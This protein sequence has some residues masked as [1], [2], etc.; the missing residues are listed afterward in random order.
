MTKCRA[1]VAVLINKTA[2]VLFSNTLHVRQIN[3]E[4]Q[5]QILD[6]YSTRRWYSQI[7]TDFLYKVFHDGDDSYHF[8]ISGALNKMAL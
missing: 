2:G 5:M 4:G 6:T 8:N 1:T 3:R 7:Y